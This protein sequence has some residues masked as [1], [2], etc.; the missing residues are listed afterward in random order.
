MSNVVSLFN[1]EIIKTDKPIKK[2]EHNLKADLFLEQI[3]RPALEVSGMHS[4]SAE[5]L[6]LGTALV[7][8]ELNSVKQFGNGP[9][10]S[11]FQIEPETYKDVAKY[12]KRK[13]RI[14]ECVLASCFMEVF[15][16]AK[17]LAWNMRLSV[18]IARVIYWRIPEPLPNHNDIVGL[19]NY[20]K[21]NYNTEKGKGEVGDFVE[22]WRF[23]VST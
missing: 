19:A 1:K 13:F 18:L 7:E 8:S 15:P 23:Y 9:A 4:L 6:L 2:E 3:I 22:K 14:K 5:N 12:L 16:P 20:W 21:D 11:F 17:C 10:L